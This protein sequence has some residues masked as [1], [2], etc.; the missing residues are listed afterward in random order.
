I[1]HTQGSG[2]TALTF[3][4][5]RFLT[6]HFQ[7]RQIVPK[8]YFIVDRLDL[9]QQAQREFIARGLTVYTIDSREAFTRAIKTTQ[10]IHNHSGKPEITVVNIQKF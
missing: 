7:K 6:D 2:K 8:F 1:W 5:V 9:L 4:N 3:Y 10:V